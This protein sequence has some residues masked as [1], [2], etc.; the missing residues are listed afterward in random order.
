MGKCIYICD[1][2]KLT[3]SSWVESDLDP[4]RVSKDT[5]GYFVWTV[6]VAECSCSVRP[7]HCC[8]RR[9]VDLDGEVIVLPDMLGGVDA[10]HTS[11][12]NLLI[13]TIQALLFCLRHTLLYHLSLNGEVESL[14]ISFSV[15]QQ[16]FP[17]RHPWPVTLNEDIFWLVSLAT[18]RGKK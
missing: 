10:S 7:A 5:L 17:V 14:S 6:W 1:L 16:P 3:F 4:K 9:S 15:L 18:E 2:V 8:T 11:H 12:K 13:K